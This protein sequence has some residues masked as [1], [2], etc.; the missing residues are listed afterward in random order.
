MHMRK[1]RN[2]SRLLN[3][4]VIGKKA[5]AK[6]LANVLLIK[7]DHVTNTNI[8]VYICVYSIEN[9]ITASV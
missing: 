2:S 7:L 5:A 8:S 9:D 6:S 3:Q 4:A 1:N